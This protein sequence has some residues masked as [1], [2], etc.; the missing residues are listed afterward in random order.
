MYKRHHQWLDE[1]WLNRFL[2]KEFHQR[3]WELLIA[4]TL[5]SLGFEFGDESGDEGPDFVG[6]LFGIDVTVECVSYSPGQEG[7]PFS[8]PRTNY[9]YRSGIEAMGHKKGD[10][11]PSFL[12][13][14][15]ISLRV[16][17]AF[18]AKVLQLQQHKS[19]GFTS[20]IHLIAIGNGGVKPGMVHDNLPHDDAIW[21]LFLPFKATGII[22][23]DTGEHG[24]ARET[25]T[26]KDKRVVEKPFLM[27][28]AKGVAGVL[29]GTTLFSAGHMP[30]EDKLYWVR[31]PYA[32]HFFDIPESPVL[33]SLV[34][35]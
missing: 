19:S 16:S 35:C 13:W 27:E 24:I 5:C 33:D 29:F 3:S 23:L 28:G 1:S 22:D 11:Y 7:K 2:D 25:D 8:V 32:D 12:H 17:N 4:D 14:N 9:E 31:N 20:R 18:K 30:W 26:P 21:R 10:G 34:G 15:E 6:R